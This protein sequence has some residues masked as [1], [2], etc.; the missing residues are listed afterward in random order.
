MNPYQQFVSELGQLMEKGKDFPLGGF[1]PAKRPLI[2]PDAPKVMIFS[3]HPD[4]ECIVG[5]LPLRLMRQSQWKVINVAVTQGSNKQRQQAR[6]AELKAAC[7]FLGFALLQT[8][9]NGLESIN[10]RK[11][12]QNPSAWRKDVDLI[13][14]ILRQEKPRLILFPHERDN[15]STHVGTFH[16]LRDALEDCGTSCACWIA[17]TEFWS[18]M[19]EP[20][21]M[22][23][24]S[25]QEVGDLITALS[26]HAGEV[27]RNPYHLRAP[28]WMI[29]NVRRGS[30]LVGAQ[31]GAAPDFLY[32]TLYRMGRWRNGA[33]EDTGH[34]K[35]FLPLE[36]DAGAL[37]SA[38]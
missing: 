13:A 9:E 6:L 7:D 20:N 27:Q 30:E 2:T 28:C 24:S 21:L 32:A 22:V 15:N 34:P 4:D 8:G 14:N 29:D 17:Q 31:G 19:D 1:S 10:G 11:R 12:E 5:A 33:W 26:F 3:P 35:Q 36:E 38:F 37:F 25:G 18:P 16:L 23:Q